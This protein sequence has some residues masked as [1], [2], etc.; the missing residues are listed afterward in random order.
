MQS[1]FMQF[2]SQNLL[3]EVTFLTEF[4][5]ISRHLQFQLPG[6]K[7]TQVS[8]IVLTFNDIVVVRK[9]VLKHYILFSNILHQ[10]GRFLS[11]R[12]VNDYAICY[13]HLLMH[14]TCYKLNRIHFT[15]LNHDVKHALNGHSIKP[16]LIVFI[17][18]ISGR[19]V[20]PDKKQTITPLH[21]TLAEMLL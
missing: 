13:Q 2:F 7:I 11:Y 14:L 1:L 20:S 16:S 17:T 4:L 3:K 15:K 12:F 18:P 9:T 6:M 19:D 5:E 8:C 21:L 10:R